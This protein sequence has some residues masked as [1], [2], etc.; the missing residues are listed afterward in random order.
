[1]RGNLGNLRQN[2]QILHQPKDFK[3]TVEPG[4]V[5]QASQGGLPASLRLLLG[6]FLQL[7]H[8]FANPY[9]TSVQIPLA[10]THPTTRNTNPLNYVGH[11]FLRGKQDCSEN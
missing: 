2:R 5:V 7:S 8:W 4:R 3:R 10:V 6:R 9:T 1:M 11:A